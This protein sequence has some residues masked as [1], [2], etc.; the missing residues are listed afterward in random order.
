MGGNKR[1]SFGAF[2]VR[3]FQN[4]NAILSALPIQS[5]LAATAEETASVQSPAASVSAPVTTPLSNR[6][7]TQTRG[8]RNFICLV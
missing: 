3:V 8:V 1:V 7:V 2:D 4:D 6:F 5:T